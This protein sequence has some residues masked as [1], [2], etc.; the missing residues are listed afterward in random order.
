[1]VDF[2]SVLLIFSIILYTC[3]VLV[4]IRKNVCSAL[5]RHF[6]LLNIRNLEENISM[7]HHNTHTYTKHKN[8]IQKLRLSAL[9]I[10][11]IVKKTYNTIYWIFEYFLVMFLLRHTIRS[12]RNHIYITIGFILPPAPCEIRARTAKTRGGKARHCS[13]SSP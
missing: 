5:R 8:C 1:M 9:F 11:Y 6:L 4:V 10:L 12:N 2:N 7:F 13:V 3:Q